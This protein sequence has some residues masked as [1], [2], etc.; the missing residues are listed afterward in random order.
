MNTR[1][2]LQTILVHAPAHEVYEIWMDEEKHA[3]L[4][5][6]AARISRRVGGNYITDNGNTS[7]YFLELY[8]DRKIV[9]SWRMKDWPEGNLSTV[10]IDLTHAGV[11]TQITFEQTNIPEDLYEVVL[12]GWNS[13]YWEPLKRKFPPH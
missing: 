1:T 12:N 11:D 3:E 10:S 7:G 8:P 6:A 2:I 4:T 5:G 13:R 9:Q